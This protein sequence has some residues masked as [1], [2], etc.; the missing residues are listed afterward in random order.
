MC[1][2]VEDELNVR[3]DNGRES[4]YHEDF[5]VGKEGECGSRGSYQ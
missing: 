5:N 3:E 4:G 1:L 2:F